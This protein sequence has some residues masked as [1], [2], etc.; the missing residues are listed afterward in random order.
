MAPNK[1]IFQSEELVVDWISFKFQYLDNP[2]MM[3]IANYLFKIGFNSYQESGKLAQPIK[4]P[5]LVNL[6]NKF[7]VLF[8]KEGPYWQGTTLQFSGSNAFVFYAFVQKKL[9][10]WT[11]FSSGV[12]SR[13]D[14]Y[15][16]RTNKIG[17]KISDTEFF[18]NSQKELSRRNRNVNLEKNSKGFILKIGSRRSNNYFRIYQEKNSLK[19]EHEMKGKFLQKYHSLLVENKLEEFEQKLSLHFLHSFGKLLP[20]NYS[21]LDW[22]V[23]KL[24][25][26]RK[27]PI[28]QYGLNLHYVQKNGFQL[29]NDRKKFVSLLQFLVYAKNVDY[30]IGYLEPTYYRLVT[31]RVQDFFKF[32]NP[33]VKSTNYYQFKK[34]I[35][36]FD[37]L[38][39]NSLIKSFTDKRYR[40]LVTIPEVNLQ[41]SKQNCWVAKVW[42]SEE[43]F[44]YTYPFLLPDFFQQKLTK[45]EFEVRF[46]IIQV[47]SSIN[48]VKEFFI[49][50]FLD[51]Y[52]SVLSNQR[53]TKIKKLFIQSVK[54]FQ[55]YDLIE[56]DYKII[57]D[58]YYCS[59]EELTIYNISEG[60]VLSEKLSI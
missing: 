9:I 45:D 24:R 34:L 44:N 3:P 55:Q 37:E 29:F 14:L 54:L 41:K 50:E 26:I 49:Q 23:I 48:I 30:K 18:E 59:V 1:L 4:K 22:L 7:E 58:G 32:Q 46:K 2:T 17:D 51:S 53:R 12:L 6:K 56:P 25:P 52:P 21:Y 20:L 43:L 16:S 8:I 10:D 60:F 19:F 27:Q 35:Q 42:I 40:S 57:Y 47:F 33:N 39:S 38:Q 31:F 5:I 13:F 11:I 15:Y 28:L 36:F